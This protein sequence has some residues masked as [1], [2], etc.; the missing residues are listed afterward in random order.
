[1]LSSSDSVLFVCDVE[2]HGLSNDVL[3]VS[4]EGSGDVW[5]FLLVLSVWCYSLKQGV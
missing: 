4:Y 5:M 2:E 3:I 1:M